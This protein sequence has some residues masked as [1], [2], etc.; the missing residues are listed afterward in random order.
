[1]R[2]F[3]KNAG[4]LLILILTLFVFAA[5]HT[6]QEAAS[7]PSS[8]AAP[9]P[10]TT[11]A[12]TETTEPAETEPAPYELYSAAA[13]KTKSMNSKQSDSSIT[14]EITLKRG[15]R[16]TSLT[17]RQESRQITVERED[18]ATDFYDETK[19]SRR[20]QAFEDSEP[21]EVVIE[22]TVWV[23]DGTAYVQSSQSRFK[24]D[25]LDSIGLKSLEEERGLGIQYHLTP[26]WIDGAELAKGNGCTMYSLTVPAEGARPFVV[27]ELRQMHLL[28]RA[29]SVD[30]SEEM[31]TALE[32]VMELS[33]LPITVGVDEDGYLFKMEEHITCRFVLSEE[34]QTRILGSVLD[35]QYEIEIKMDGVSELLEPGTEFS[36]EL[37]ENADEFEYEADLKGKRTSAEI[38][39]LMGGERLFT[40]EQVDCM[41]QE[42]LFACISVCDPENAAK[43]YEQG[44]SE[45]IA[46]LLNEKFFARTGKRPVSYQVSGYL[47]YDVTDEI[48]QQTADWFEKNYDFV[49]AQYGAY[50][51][52]K[53]Q[54]ENLCRQAM[55]FLQ[56]TTTDE[57]GRTE[58]SP[59]D[60]SAGMM[61][62]VINGRYF[63][64]DYSLFE[65]VQE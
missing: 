57:N 47:Q 12:P 41:A 52:Q 51:A 2:I 45:T 7:A 1:M 10:E 60:P 3:R 29:L 22:S 48:R 54:E 17:E 65:S 53:V 8:T 6:P 21:K 4:M 58:Q 36:V 34:L 64:S 61:F 11:S 14:V 23:K 33:D 63:W 20:Y 9:S 25:D 30:L 55:I 19:T 18:A 15:D 26:E 35:A 43:L 62:Q 50:Y 56:Y 32:D 39:E 28:K 37:P 27:R 46:A 31:E 49:A 40:P 44:D 59:A 16:T 13:E 42:F 38:S 5:C 24:T